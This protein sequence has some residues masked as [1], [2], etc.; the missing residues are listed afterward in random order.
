MEELKVIKSLNDAIV[1]INAREDKVPEEYLSKIMNKR[2]MYLALKDY[3]EGKTPAVDVNYDCLVERIESIENDIKGFLN[4]DS[5]VDDFHNYDNGS[6]FAY[7]D[8]ITEL[9]L[10]RDLKS[11]IDH[12]KSYDSYLFTAVSY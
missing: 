8:Y 5:T 2:N 6:G 9:K 11:Y 12:G 10:L 7:M 3:R 1:Y 4:G